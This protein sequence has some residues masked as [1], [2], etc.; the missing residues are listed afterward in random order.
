MKVARTTGLFAALLL[1]AACVTINI[2]FPAAEADEAAEKIVKDILGKEEQPAPPAEDKGAMLPQRTDRSFVGLALDFLIPPAQAATPDFNV[3][4]PK[5][6]GIQA[7][8]RKRH[9]S[10]NPYYASGAIGYTQNG[11]LGIRKASAVPL[12]ERNRMKKLVAG[13]N[14]DRNALY[15]AIANANGH[16]E[17]EPEVRATFAKKW[18][19]EANS[20]WW[21]QDASGAWK[22]K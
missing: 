13:D 21:Y 14:K 6:R 11:L 10:L 2:Y 15:K 5:I 17:W 1:L 9:Q 3:D 22:Q 4:T 8:M 19:Q 7:S 18:V 20:G 12:K 16:P